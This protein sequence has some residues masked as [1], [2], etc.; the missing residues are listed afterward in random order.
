MTRPYDHVKRANSAGESP[1][2]PAR[3]E[4]ESPAAPAREPTAREALAALESRR[5]SRAPGPNDFQQVGLGGAP[6]TNSYLK[7]MPGDWKQETSRAAALP[8]QGVRPLHRFS[9]EPL[10]GLRPE[11]VQDTFL[12]NLPQGWT[13]PR[14]QYESV[15]GKQLTADLTNRATQAQNEWESRNPEVGLSPA[16]PNYRPAWFDRDV[17]VWNAAG[18]PYEEAPSTNDPVEKMREDAVGAGYVPSLGWV[19]GE[20]TKDPP[21]GGFIDQVPQLNRFNLPGSPGYRA[22]MASPAGESLLD[23]L[24]PYN[25]YVPE[26]LRFEGLNDLHSLMGLHEAN[27]ALQNFSKMQVDTSGRNK[28]PASFRPLDEEKAYR[29]VGSSLPKTV[30]KR[31]LAEAEYP[32]RMVE[33]PAHLSEMK[34]RYYRDTGTAPYMDDPEQRKAFMDYWKSRLEEAPGRSGLNIRYGPV[35]RYLDTLS[36]PQEQEFLLRSIV[37][38]R[39]YSE[40]Q[41]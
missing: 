3:F 5:A 9:W 32:L 6:I 40:Y 26:Y 14:A 18:S 29:V 38:N 21:P 2:A 25:E 37:G 24:K 7:D 33:F 35:F 10:L 4:R 30:N 19:R 20:E 11:Q 23:T 22:L 27:H 17:P 28:V 36:D 8:G 13:T 1:A 12:K 34:A 31:D 15:Y 16:I 39:P 41:A